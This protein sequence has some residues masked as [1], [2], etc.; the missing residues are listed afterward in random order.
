MTVET[1]AI[2]QDAPSGEPE[3]PREF[4]AFSAFR[5]ML[6][7]ED[8]EP[9]KR[10][11]SD[12]EAEGPAEADPE[13]DGDDYEP[14][15]EGDEVAPEP[16]D[17]DGDEAHPEDGSEE[18]EV[19]PEGDDVEVI[20]RVDGEDRKVSV[21]D[22]KRL[23]GQE[24]ALTRKSQEVSAARTEAQVKTDRAIAALAKLREKAE[25]RLAPYRG[26]DWNIV[27]ADYSRDVYEQLKVDAT[28]AA[29]DLKFL[30]EELDGHLKAAQ[31]ERHQQ[32]QAAAAEAVK[33]LSNPET[34]IPNWGEAV[35]R[36]IM[37]YGASQ[38]VPMELMQAATDPVLIKAFHKAM[39][40]DRAQSQVKA[41]VKPV[42]VASAKRSL[43]AN[44]TTAKSTKQED[45]MVRLRKS[46]GSRDAAVDAFRAYFAS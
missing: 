12:P 13:E 41:V 34:G 26:V 42:A 40:W 23:Y 44:K 11:A 1:G 25:A 17:E 31:A 2:Q 22:L 24:A 10:R 15:D 19:T 7:G 43:S 37:E 45:A 30:N 18:T 29:E 20:V 21:R 8:N 36:E 39:L 9:R 5:D 38:G 32:V 33:V 35:Y 28:A 16:G 14:T 6:S 27:A 4:D 3:A 46:N